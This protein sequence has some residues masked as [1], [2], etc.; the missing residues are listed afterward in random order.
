MSTTY[1]NPEITQRIREP[2]FQ[3]N[4]ARFR[5]SRESQSEN[6]E[7]N[8]L[9]LDLTRILNELENIDISI[10]GKLTYIIGDVNDVTSTVN[11]DDGLSYEIPDVEIYDDYAYPQYEI[12]DTGPGGGKIFITPLTTGNT[13]G[14][15]F[16]VAPIETE[17][18]RT[19]PETRTN[20][21]PNP[22][23]ETNTTGWAGT[24][25]TLERIT[26][27]SYIGTASLSVT[28][29]SASDTLV[30]LN[31][32]PNSTVG[33]GV[34]VTASAY[35]YNFA[36]L[37]RQHRID[38]RCWNAGFLIGTI[39]GTATTI[40]VGAGWT[41][42]SVSGTTV[43]STNNIDIS[44]YTQANNPSLSNVSYIDAV[45]VER[46]STLNSYFDGSTNSNTS[47]AGTVNNSTSTK[48]VSGADET[49]IGSGE[50][51]TIDIVAESGGTSNTSAAVYCSGLTFGDK[52]DW[53]LPS[54]DELYQIYINS[55]VLNSN[56][57]GTYFSSSEVNGTNSWAQS[58]VLGTQS[59][60]IKSALA[61]VRPVRA[62]AIPMKALEIHTTNKLSG[63]LSRLL[64]KIQ[65]LEN[66]N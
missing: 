11:L 10:L 32:D 54:L 57:T 62:F 65:R 41:R 50:Q 13:T 27:A 14:K 2:L 61:N 26:S 25:C 37:S 38:L 12:G 56:F 1:N 23:F 60:T 39:T 24:M 4:R 20:L 8:F 49:V 16:E 35:I 29:T 58:F 28:S 45:L 15:Y 3:V 44:I 5:G 53:F 64:N 55:E 34:Q 17:V 18:S 31:Y 36:G 59:S 66:G 30:R 19:W 22:S 51:N 21:C 40:N 48:E 43:A 33:A 6:L 42:V 46:S 47:W 7:T 63:K 9:Q 52:S